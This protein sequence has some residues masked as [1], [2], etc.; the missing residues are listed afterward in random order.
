M[1]CRPLKAKFTNNGVAGRC[2]SKLSL[3][4]LLIKPETFFCCKQDERQ[5]AAQATTDSMVAAR[6][7]AVLGAHTILK[8]CLPHVSDGL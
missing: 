5:A 3:V 7:G 1:C 2:L 8:V 6:T 4:S